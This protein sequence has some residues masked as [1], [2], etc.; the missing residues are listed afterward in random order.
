MT[1]LIAY[2]GAAGIAFTFIA[3][4]EFCKRRFPNWRFS[5]WF[6]RNIAYTKD[7]NDLTD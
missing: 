1:G 2:F 6:N 5:K 3:F 4:G 7:P